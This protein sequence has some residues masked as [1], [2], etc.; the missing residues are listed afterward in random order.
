M[1]QRAHEVRRQLR[2]G[3]VLPLGGPADG[4]WITERAAAGVLRSAVAALPGIRLGTLRLSVPD[5]DRAPLPAVPPPPS[6]LPPGPLRITADFTAATGPPLPAVADRLRTALLTAAH[7]QL[8]LLVDTVDLEVSGVWEP[9]ATGQDAGEAG[10][11]PGTSEAAGARAAY[12]TGS[13][14]GPLGATGEAHDEAAQVAAA[15]LAVPGVTRPAPALGVLSRPVRL[16][17]GHALVQLAAAGGER[18]LDVARA[19]R[20]AVTALPAGPASVA[21]LVTAV[22]TD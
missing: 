8:G 18:T 10:P 22:D 21:V 20:A 4:A 2:P 1:T 6:A 7:R 11:A 12:D 3:R 19:V 17:A 15:V 9:E 13:A 16:D 14:P 5:A